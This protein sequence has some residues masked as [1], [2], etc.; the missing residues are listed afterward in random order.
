MHKDNGV[1][2]IIYPTQINM[3]KK[4]KLIN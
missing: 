3:Q 2:L 4:L 1:A